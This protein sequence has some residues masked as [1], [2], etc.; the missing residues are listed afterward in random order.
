M[1]T[2][3]KL[4]GT[5][6]IIKIKLCVKLYIFIFLLCIK[7]N[8]GDIM[9]IVPNINSNIY[10]LSAIVIGYILLDDAT[11][12]EQNSLGNWFMLIGQVLCTYSSQQQVLNNR[13]GNS[14]S[15]NNHI[16]NDNI[17]E[18]KDNLNKNYEQDDYDKQIIMMKK[19]IS[20]MQQEIDNL[21]K[22]RF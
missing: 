16:I 9:S 19:V 22:E 11:P 21:K 2:R 15:S 18:E 10:T 4:D 17:S 7:L 3:L 8:S 14:N 1:L 6:Y 13:N 20:A 12:A 5:F